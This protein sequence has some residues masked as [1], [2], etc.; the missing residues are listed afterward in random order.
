MQFQCIRTRVISKGAMEGRQSIG[1]R[2]LSA[3][4]IRFFVRHGCWATSAA[5]CNS[6]A[7][8]ALPRERW[9]WVRFMQWRRLFKIQHRKTAGAESAM[10][11]GDRN[12]VARAAHA[13]VHGG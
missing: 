11:A 6:Y 9:E 2:E 8:E 3:Q 1:S 4:Y 7:C 10:K 12:D 5:P 13:A